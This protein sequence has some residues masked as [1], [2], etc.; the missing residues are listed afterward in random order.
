MNSKKQQQKI[1][2]F[3]FKKS[4]DQEGTINAKN[5]QKVLKE[6]VARKPP[7][8]LHILKIYKKITETALAKEQIIIESAQKTA[9]FKK[10]EAKL[11]ERTGA[12]RIIFKINPSIVLGTKITHGDRIWDNTL[13]GKLKRLTIDD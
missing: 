6:I 5:V 9:N 8:L 1:A 2:K 10:L 11:Q 3:L 4:L 13:E 12:K 7:Q